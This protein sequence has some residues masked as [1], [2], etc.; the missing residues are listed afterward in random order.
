VAEGD[1]AEFEEFGF[2]PSP[3][4]RKLLA[5]ATARVPIEEEVAVALLGEGPGLL[6]PAGQGGPGRGY[7]YWPPGA[8]KAI[9]YVLERLR[10]PGVQSSFAAWQDLRGDSIP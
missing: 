5:E 4:E 8:A 2:D 1:F 6:Q 10:D 3:D 7:G 9:E